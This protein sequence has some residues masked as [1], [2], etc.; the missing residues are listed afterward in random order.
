MGGGKGDSPDPPNYKKIA[1]AQ[2][3]ANKESAIATAQISNPNVTNP[4]GTQVISYKKDPLTG[5]PVPYVTQAYTPEQQEIFGLGQDVQRS[6]GQ[7]GVDVANNVGATLRS[8]LDFG[9]VPAAPGDAEATRTAVINA[10]MG[11]V[12]TDIGRRREQKN[13]DLVAAGIRPGT[14]AYSREMEMIDRSENDARQQ[15]I[16]AGGQEAQRDFGMDMQSRQQAISELLAQ[17]GVPL[18]ELNAIRSGSQVA[19][20][21]FGGVQGAGVKPPDLQGAANQQYQG[22]LDQYNAKVG[23]QNQMMSTVGTLGAAA[24][25]AMF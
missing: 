16:L 12:G 22:Q 14:E 5:N 10:M 7:T 24:I 3:K 9:G 23:Q 13:S 8:P 6:L 20:L 18:N 1:E 11:R 17:R 2:G 19:P 4:L 21:Q 15:A 25:G